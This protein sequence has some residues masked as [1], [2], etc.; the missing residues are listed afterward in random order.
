MSGPSPKHPL[1]SFYRGRIR[2]RSSIA[3]NLRVMEKNV[4][5][6][7]RADFLGVR[8]RGDGHFGSA[9]G[10]DRLFGIRQ[11]GR[12][13]FFG[14]DP[15]LHKNCQLGRNSRG[16]LCRRDAGREFLCNRGSRAN[17]HPKLA[18]DEMLSARLSQP[19][20]PTCQSVC[21]RW[22]VMCCLLLIV[23]KLSSRA[24]LISRVLVQFRS[25]AARRRR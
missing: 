7:A 21:E 11:G 6:R 24:R 5:R 4:H 22:Q 20:R 3:A 12:T 25:Q 16:F 18:I 23:W 9:M 13:D 15:A 10:A 14:V 1:P 8:H 17:R 19:S 2:S